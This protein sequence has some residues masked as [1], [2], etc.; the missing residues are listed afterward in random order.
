MML[1]R[2]LPAFLLLATMLPGQEGPPELRGESKMDQRIRE[3]KARAAKA[4]E[5]GEEGKDSDQE[6]LDAELLGLS[7]EQRM[8]RSGVLSASSFCRF[9]A[10]IKPARLMP[11]Q[12]GVMVVTAVLS[13]QAVLPAP[14]TMEQVSAS[15]QGLVSLG[16][17]SFRPAEL[18]KL[19]PGYLGR[20][21][22]DNYAVFEIPVTM[23]PQAE[24]GK[25]QAVQV[26]LRFEI[27]DGTTAQSIGR[28][29]DRAAAEV[30]VGQVA[31]PYVMGLPAT[32]T[33]TPPAQAEF[34]APAARAEPA[35]DRVIAGVA[36]LTQPA[37]IAESS[38]VKPAAEATRPS[39]LTLGDSEPASPMPLIVGGGLLLLVIG[40]LVARKK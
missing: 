37:S 30:E 27:Y 14:A 10:S 1:F 21:V 4:K 36:P 9:I 31:D 34:V 19:A 16:A 23:S 24:L 6:R 39:E 29:L 22:Y 40:F 13:G 7:P 32:N 8:Q 3:A 33:V 20:P 12:S 26:D 2:T 28:F 11:G 5:Q 35:S 15:Q 17:L 25:K 38:E 18:G